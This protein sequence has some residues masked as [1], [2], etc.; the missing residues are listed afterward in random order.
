ME[1]KARCQ[2]CGMPLGEGFYGT[3]TDGLQALEYCKFCYQKGEY[4]QPDL[5][6]QEMIEMS[7]ENMIEKKKMP[8]EKAR[9]LASNFIPQLKRWQE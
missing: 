6:M 5:L 1:E 9:E 8:E 7:I 3:E 4:T 2:S